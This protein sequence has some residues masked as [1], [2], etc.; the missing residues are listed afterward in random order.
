MESEYNPEAFEWDFSDLLP[1]FVEAVLADEPDVKG[2]RETVPGYL[3]NYSGSSAFA[4]AVTYFDPKS[5]LVQQGEFFEFGDLITDLAAPIED[6]SFVVTLYQDKTQR[7]QHLF[8]F[9]DKLRFT[10]HNYSLR[11]VSYTLINPD[12]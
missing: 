3:L 1:G 5:G 10:T 9:S 2:I 7:Y 4:F 12:Q 11:E 6:V 8:P